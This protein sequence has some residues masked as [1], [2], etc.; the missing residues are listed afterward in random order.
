MGTQFI[1]SIGPGAFEGTEFHPARQ[2]EGHVFAGRHR[3]RGGHTPPNSL[4]APDLTVNR[5]AIKFFESEKFDVNHKSRDAQREQFRDD[6][7]P[8]QPALLDEPFRTL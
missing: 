4:R 1:E 8:P 5:L 3:D 6:L 2:D 7:S